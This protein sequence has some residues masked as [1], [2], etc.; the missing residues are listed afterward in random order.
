MSETENTMLAVIERVASLPDV[1]VLKLQAM[2]DMQERVMQKNAEIAFNQAMARLQPALPVIR[3]TS[4]AHNSKYAK[5]EKIESLVRP[6]YTAEGFSMSY[7]VERNADGTETYVG[8]VSHVDGHKKQARLT[9]PPDT[10]GSKNNIQAKGSTVSYARRYLLC[11]LLNIVTSDD[12]DGDSR[13]TKI[14][15]KQANEI[16]AKIAEVG[17]N[18]AGFLKYMRVESVDAIPEADFQKAMTALNEK[19][20]K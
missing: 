3:K 7:D 6:L 13:T 4:K 2:L 9:L 11:M 19:S 10:S 20:K 5:F 17:A 8:T 1:D 12:D 15:Q 18:K 14:N 16:N